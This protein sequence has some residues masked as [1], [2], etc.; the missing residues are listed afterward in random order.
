MDVRREELLPLPER[1]DVGERQVELASKLDG[2]HRVSVFEVTGGKMTLLAERLLYRQ[3]TH[4]LD[5]AAKLAKQTGDRVQ[6]DIGCKDEAGRATAF[7]GLASVVDDRFVN[8]APEPTLT[9]QFLVLGDLAAEFVDQPILVKPAGLDLA[10]GI[11]GW[12]A[13]PPQTQ[14][15]NAAGEPKADALRKAEEKL[16]AQDELAKKEGNRARQLG[17]GERADHADQAGETTTF[18]SRV[19]PNPAEIRQRLTVLAVTARRDL[20]QRASRDRQELVDQRNATIRERAA[21]QAEL[22]VLE[23]QPRELAM[24]GLGAVTLGSLVVGTLALLWGFARLVRGGS[25]SASFGVAFAGI[26]ASLVLLL[27][28]P[29][30]VVGPQPQVAERGKAELRDAAPKVLQRAE[31]V[32]EKEILERV[33][34]TNVHIP[35]DGIRAAEPPAPAAAGFA[36]AAQPGLG[37][38]GGGG[39]GGRQLA[40]Q[41]QAAMARLAGQR[42]NPSTLGIRRGSLQMKLAKDAESDGKAAQGIGGFGGGLPGAGPPVAANPLKG[43]A[44]DKANPKLNA[45]VAE[46]V[47]PPAAKPENVPAPTPTPATPAP[48]G[49]GNNG[50]APAPAVLSPYAKMATPPGRP[51]IDPAGDKDMFRELLE[52]AAEN[53]DAVDIGRLRREF[54]MRRSVDVAT[55]LWSPALHVPAGGVTLSFDVPADSARYRILI[56]GHTED[57]RFGSFEDRLVVT[58]ANSRRAP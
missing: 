2:I 37:G 14:L 31:A 13:A 16:R 49:A 6:L 18:F 24:M 9:E 40:Q 17:E 48:A 39:A 22:R 36:V 50:P 26:A 15:A 23:E 34:A 20:D 52:S 32:A 54:G 5:L 38:N 47:A 42:D 51:A 56:L 3:P 53:A 43:A 57:G 12:Q 27:F 10:L 1:A 30:D 44:K 46:P 41:E 25:A 55:L 58:P 4:R 33:D 8:D 28:R 7:F 35:V 11:L 19:E 29:N 21:A 45:K